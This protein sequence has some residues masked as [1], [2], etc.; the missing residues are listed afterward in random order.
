M[1]LQ[2]CFFKNTT[3]VF[4]LIAHFESSFCWWGSWARA[5]HAGPIFWT[6]H[7]VLFKELRYSRTDQSAAEKHRFEEIPNTNID[8][9]KGCVIFIIALEK[10]LY[11]HFFIHMLYVFEWTIQV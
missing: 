4:T 6:V 8:Y 11:S 10:F 2:N 1:A 7:G 3:P 5:V 9:D